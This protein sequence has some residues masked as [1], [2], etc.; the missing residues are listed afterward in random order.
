MDYDNLNEFYGK[1]S[2][3]DERSAADRPDETAP[4]YHSLQEHLQDALKWVNQVVLSHL[5]HLHNSGV[6]FPDDDKTGAARRGYEPESLLHSTDKQVIA[7]SG[8]VSLQTAEQLWEKI[9]AK[10]RASREKKI[11][12]P[13]AE[14]QERFGLNETALQILLMAASVELDSQSRRL[15]TR[16]Q[17]ELNHSGF[18]PALIIEVLSGANP[19]VQKWQLY[20]Y[21][22]QQ[23]PLFKHLLLRE[24]GSG[25]SGPL[26]QATLKI[27]RRILQYILGNQVPD[28]V[29][30]YLFR[31]VN[32]DTAAPAW[33]DYQQLLP[34]IKRRAE[35]QI[36]QPESPQHAIFYF[37]GPA[38]SGKKSLAA[39]V[40]RNLGARLG[41][42]DLQ[43]VAEFGDDFSPAIHTACREAI[44]QPCALLIDHFEL[45]QNQPQA[46]AALFAAMH[47]YSWL[48]FISSRTSPAEIPLELPVIPLELKLPGQE[49][50]QQIW[51]NYIS[52]QQLPVSPEK[53]QEL[54]ARFILSGGQIEKA[55]QQVNLRPEEGSAVSRQEITERLFRAA[56]ETS[57]PRL[58]RLARK[59]TSAYRFDDIVLPPDHIL[60]LKEIIISVRQRHTVFEKWGF[61]KKMV[62][63]R[64]IMALFSGPSGTGK[65]MAAQILANELGLD[66][67]RIDLSSVVSKYIGET[68]KNLSRIFDEAQNSNAVLF[69]D[70][71]DALFGKRS[72]VKDAHDRYANIEIGY[73]LQ[74]ME[75]YDGVAILAT[76]LR[77][78]IDEAFT[79]RMRF[80]VDFPFPDAAQRERI[81]RKMLP[82][83]LPAAPDLD[84][85]FL[86]NRFKMTGGNIRN[87]VLTAAML[88]AEKDGQLKMEH[89]I[90]ATRRELQKM[91][92]LLDENEFGKY[93][94][95]IPAAEERA[96]A[97][98]QNRL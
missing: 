74:R 67:F 98:A 46:R 55:V 11:Y 47:A 79:R 76:N 70:E 27:D 69:F 35:E 9:A 75:D 80:I 90:R 91:G 44:L 57:Q 39:L 23:A 97:G 61:G 59:M 54:S 28:E 31:L 33:V 49:S 63:G 14:L 29:S 65:T 7:E 58:S 34:L 71:A 81:W 87:I 42:V 52:A 92:R 83:E 95:A 43:A 41:I 20:N 18:S 3:S 16:L 21:F 72:E 24:N 1:Q 5:R 84:F 6:S 19:G 8:E 36:R 78:H 64:G 56:R 15:L 77:N 48:T 17:K 30:A 53:V 25:F 12:L 96:L 51:S 93:R 85:P 89:L 60:H 4:A 45:L 40:C 88:A 26:S 94:E 86:A 37:H 13:L 68:E 38:G 32:T 2:F 22:N 73:M 82:E 62:Q 66:L 50:R 10:A